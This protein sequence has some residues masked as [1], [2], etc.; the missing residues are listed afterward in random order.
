MNS[1]LC[2]RLVQ[3]DSAMQSPTSAAAAVAVVSRDVRAPVVE[4][5]CHRRRVFPS[6]HDDRQ[7]DTPRS[8]K[9]TR[10]RLAGRSCTDDERRT[11][12]RRRLTS[13]LKQ[14][15]SARRTELQLRHCRARVQHTASRPSAMFWCAL[16]RL[17]R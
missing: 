6:P 13:R 11:T 9:A 5:T 15:V 17:R 8:S 4:K 2:H 12:R 16:R 14:S 7:T 10:Q 3:E 1:D